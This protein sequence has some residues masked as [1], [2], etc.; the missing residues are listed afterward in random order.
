M[1]SGIKKNIKDNYNEIIKSK[2]RSTSKKED[3]T[4]AEAFELYMLKNFHDIK[5]NDLSQKILDF[6]KMILTKQLKTTL[7]F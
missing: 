2:K 6:G 7:N 4:I 5:L 1:L 3:V